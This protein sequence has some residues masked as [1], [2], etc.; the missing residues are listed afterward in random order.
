MVEVT[1]TVNLV[2][3][4]IMFALGLVIVILLVYF[5]IRTIQYKHRIIIREVARDRK[6]ISYDKAREYTDRDGITYWQFLKKRKI[7]IQV[8]PADA[9][10]ID[11]KGRKCVQIYLLET[12]DVQFIKD[13]GLAKKPPKEITEIKDISKRAKKLAEW[14]KENE[15]IEG[16]QPLPTNQRL[17]LINQIEKAHARRKKKWQDYIMPVAGLTALIIIVVSLMIFW[18]DMARPLLESMDKYNQNVEIQRQSLEIIQSIKQDIQVIGGNTG[19]T[20]EPPN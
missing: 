7:K 16:F 9:I 4:V 6:L 18:G 10:E 19:A 17:I 11:K 13:G 15:V 2:W 8:P 1:N 20:A 14:K 5:I 3:Q 12:G